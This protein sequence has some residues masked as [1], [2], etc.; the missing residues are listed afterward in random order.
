MMCFFE[1]IKYAGIYLDFYYKYYFVGC[2]KKL[3]MQNLQKGLFAFLISLIS[4]ASFSQKVNFD[5]VVTPS[6]MGTRNFKEYIVQLAWINSP[7]NDALTYE[8]K[9]R[10]FELAKEKKNWMDD[11]R[12]SVNL[13]ET[14]FSRD[15]I[16]LQSGTGTEG[17]A[18]ITNLFPIFN[19][20][21]SV[22]LATFANR[23]NKLGIAEQRIKIAEANVN[24][25]VL[26]ASKYC[27]H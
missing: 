25:I 13:N 11:V 18:P 24:I 10:E 5:K 27:Q 26:D 15:T 6:E 2:F 16:V 4:F 17:A 21:A 12:F 20:H 19:L 23:K 7:E 22:N 14:H 3:K 1:K 9:L 8:Q